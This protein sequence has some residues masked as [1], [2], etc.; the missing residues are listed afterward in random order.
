[1]T[2]ADLIANFHTG[3]HDFESVPVCFQYRWDHGEITDFEIESAQLAEKVSRY[4]LVRFFG[5][6]A[7]SEAEAALVQQILD[8]PTDYLEAAE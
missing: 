4:D 3:T 1:M 2:T 7:V 6:D 8:Y 5:E